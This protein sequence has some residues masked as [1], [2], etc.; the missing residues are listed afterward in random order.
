M[1]TAYKF[2]QRGGGIGGT[3]GYAAA[4]TLVLVAERIRIQ[5]Q[6]NKNNEIHTSLCSSAGERQQKYENLRKDVEKTKNDDF[7]SSSKSP[8][9]IRRN[10]LAPIGVPLPIPRIITST[11][12]A[13]K[14]P[15]RYIDQ[16]R[17]D[18]QQLRKLLIETGK[19]ARGNPE[20]AKEL[21]HAIFEITYGKGITPQQREDFLLQYGCTGWTDEIVS[22]IIDVCE[23]RGIVELGAGHGQWARAL[24]EAYDKY[25]NNQDDDSMTAATTAN[26]KTKKKRFDFVLAYDDMSSLPLN[27]HVYNQYT[28]PYHQYFGKVSKLNR[29]HDVVQ[30]LRSWA[31]RGRVLLLVY[32]G[33]GKFAHDVVRQYIDASPAENDTLIYVGEGRGGANADDTFF[34]LLEAT[35]EW[36][37]LYMLNVKTPPGDKGYEKLYILQRQVKK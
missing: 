30:V 10:I 19:Q 32:P 1:V 4:A 12:P 27:T 28:K 13:L 14:L 22:T 11:D 31:C 16:R 8:S 17:K 25:K 34:D 2:K 20:K 6:D 23:S 24:S 18:E 35:E 5:G 7:V 26:A 15:K 9:W 29:P 3:L 33:P 21:G 37:L 36:T